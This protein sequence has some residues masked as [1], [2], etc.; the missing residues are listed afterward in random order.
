MTSSQR[1]LKTFRATFRRS[2]PSLGACHPRVEVDRG[3]T[4][5]GGDAVEEDG[6]DRITGD[7]EKWKSNI[8]SRKM[9]SMFVL[10]CQIQ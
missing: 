10:E 5:P 6:E 2:H 1:F 3:W 9:C 8:G 7:N 4:D